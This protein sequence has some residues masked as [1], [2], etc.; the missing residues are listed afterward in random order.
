VS[1]CKTE[2]KNQFNSRSRR[3]PPF[4]AEICHF[5]AILDAGYGAPKFFTFKTSHSP[6][7]CIANFFKEKNQ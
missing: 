7:P 4:S 1:T 3:K 2:K 5:Q 6:S